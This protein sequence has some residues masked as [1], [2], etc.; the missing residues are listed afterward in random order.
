[1]ATT[2]YTQREIKRKLLGLRNDRPQAPAGR[3]LVIVG[4]GGITVL[5]PGQKTTHGEAVWGSYHTI[6]EVDTGLKDISFFFSSPAKGG[7]VN[8][9][10]Q[11]EAGYRVSDPAE[12]VRQQLSDPEPV[13]RRAVTDTVRQV[14]IQHD[15]EDG[16]AAL[17]AVRNALLAGNLAKDVP[18]IVNTPSVTLDLDA[19]AKE[20]LRQRRE[21]HHKAAL[22]RGSAQVT[23]A[24]AQAQQLEQQFE[25][26]ARKREL[27]HQLQLQ[28]MRMD[29][30]RPVIEGG[31][32]SLLVQQLSEHPDDVGRVTEMIMRLHSA[33]AEKDL[34][35]LKTLIDNDL[36]EGRQVQNITNSLI[37]N[38]ERSMGRGLLGAT[39]DLPPKQLPDAT[40]ISPSD[41]AVD[42][43]Q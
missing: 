23:T 10:V 20:F 25:M 4:D 41:L 8:F 9:T 1:M 43:Q 6:Y 30:Y 16:E 39:E 21:Q 34:A 7:D 37:Q 5:Q 38:L 18:L 14:T 11:V 12:V 3:A 13:L 36:I 26:E 35:Y 28:Q 29:F 40:G 15:I 32:W 31:M 24:T 42:E 22:A 33:Q 19:Q 2:L 17:A 27:E